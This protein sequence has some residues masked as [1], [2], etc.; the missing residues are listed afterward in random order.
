MFF[1]HF[2]AVLLYIL[3]IIQMTKEFILKQKKKNK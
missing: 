2:S 3:V 1:T